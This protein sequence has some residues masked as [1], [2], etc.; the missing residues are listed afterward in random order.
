MPSTK[1]RYHRSSQRDA[2]LALVRQSKTH[3]TAEEIHVKLKPKYPRLSLGTVYRNLH[4]LA[5]MGELSEIHFGSGRDRFDA[6]Q[7]KHYHFIC[8]RCGEILDVE[9]PVHLELE[10]EAR[11]AAG[12]QIESHSIEFYGLCRGCSHPRRG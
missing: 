7:G 12:F 3:P 11:E 10:R 4:V 1:P 6:R 9:M 2:V 5:E 8:R